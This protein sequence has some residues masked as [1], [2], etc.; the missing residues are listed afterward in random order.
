MGNY[1]LIFQKKEI[2]VYNKRGLGT[3]YSAKEKNLIKVFI[4]AKIN[5][6]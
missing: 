6:D 5:T 2:Y 1:D 3:F 4:G